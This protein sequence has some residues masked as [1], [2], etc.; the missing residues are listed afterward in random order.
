MRL[1]AILVFLS[2]F[3]VVACT[4]EEISEV[5]LTPSEQGRLTIAE[6]NTFEKVLFGLDA[7]PGY[8]SSEFLSLIAP[9]AKSMYFAFYYTEENNT[10]TVFTTVLKSGSIEET[11]K[12]RNLDQDPEDG[13]TGTAIHLVKGKTL[14][15]IG[16]SDKSDSELAEEIANKV[17]QRLGMEIVDIDKLSDTV[18]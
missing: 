3:A 16:P 18:Q 6:L 5:T 11:L 9:D 4:S 12:S 2:V 13:E 14:T 1:I 7:N 15:T 8:A 17:A 10:M